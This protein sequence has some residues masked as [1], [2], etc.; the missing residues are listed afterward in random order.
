MLELKNGKNEIFPLKIRFT[1]L[2]KGE[3]VYALGWSM[4]QENLSYPELTKLKC[5]RD[6]G[7]YY[8]VQTISK[9][10]NQRGKSGSPVIDKNGYLVGIVSGAEGNLGVIGSVK[11]LANLLDLYQ[12]EYLRE[13]Q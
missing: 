3:I 11:Y 12:V 2:E 4:Y 13:G 7:N 10:S 6:E 8:Y 1:P 9:N 5:Y